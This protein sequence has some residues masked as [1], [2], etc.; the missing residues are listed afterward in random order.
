MKLLEKV[1]FL[2]K[3]ASQLDRQLL[4][5]VKRGCVP[6]VSK[7]AC[8]W[9]TSC[10][11]EA[12]IW[13]VCWIFLHDLISDDVNWGLLASITGP[14]PVQGFPLVWALTKI[15]SKQSEKKM[16]TS[17]YLHQLNLSLQISHENL[18]NVSLQN[19]FR[20]TMV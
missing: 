11:S 14:V 9:F 1:V 3:T 18:P 17:L 5:N 7:L 19:C 10:H 8:D 4:S 6:I 13:R 15:P 2:K 16:G 12:Q 20:R